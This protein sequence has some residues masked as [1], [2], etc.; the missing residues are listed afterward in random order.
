MD[1]ALQPLRMVILDICKCKLGPGIPT[2]SLLI[3]TP[4]F[5]I[6]FIIPL[7]NDKRALQAAQILYQGYVAL[8]T[9]ISLMRFPGR[10][11]LSLSYV[12]AFG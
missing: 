12:V 6:C 3:N 5:I 9:D 4:L 1:F 8:T 11:H 2:F 10:L 7:A